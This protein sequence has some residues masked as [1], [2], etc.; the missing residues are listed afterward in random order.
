[1]FILQLECKLYVWMHTIYNVFR[2]YGYTVS[3]KMNNSILKTLR[4][5]S[6]KPVESCSGVYKIECEVCNSFYIGQTAGNFQIDIKL[7][8]IHIQMCIRD[9]SNK[10]RFYKKI[11]SYTRY[12]DDTFLVFHGTCR[13]AEIL[14]KHINLSLIHI[15]LFTY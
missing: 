15:L 14:N 5:K 4:P 10:N 1:M 3:F 9:R 11:I 13:Q 12:V 2:K 6:N 8:L 7:S